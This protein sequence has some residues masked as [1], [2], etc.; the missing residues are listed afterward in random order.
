MFRYQTVDEARTRIKRGNKAAALAWLEQVGSWPSDDE[1]IR[2]VTRMANRLLGFPSAHNPHE[3]SQ[4][5]DTLIRFVE[6]KTEE[7]KRAVADNWPE[8]DIEALEDE[9][10]AVLQELGTHGSVYFQRGKEAIERIEARS[11]NPTIGIK[12]AV[13]SLAL[14]AVGVAGIIM[15]IRT[16]K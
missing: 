1:E 2:E 7:I 4:D 3:S 9:R 11:V 13:I 10:D 12:D 5:P 16:S 6:Q 8:E 14:A 15:G